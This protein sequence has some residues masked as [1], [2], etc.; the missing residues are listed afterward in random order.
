[1]AGQSLYISLE[2]IQL[3]HATLSFSGES[4]NVTLVRD[5]SPVSRDLLD[6]Y[7]RVK[8][9]STKI[10]ITNVNTSDVGYY[11]LKD[12]R[13]RVVSVNRMELTG[14][15]CRLPWCHYGDTTGLPRCHNRATME[16]Q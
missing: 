15:F 14:R 5:G 11:T 8:T 4:A 3:D 7:D 6:Y 2:G 13:D 1:M 16:S 12:H 10:E 9:H